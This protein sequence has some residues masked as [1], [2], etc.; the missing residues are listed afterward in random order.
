MV[1][2]LSGGKYKRHWSV[3]YGSL[4]AYKAVTVGFGK[5]AKRMTHTKVEGTSAEREDA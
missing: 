5:A 1:Q 4:G 2:Q 3:T